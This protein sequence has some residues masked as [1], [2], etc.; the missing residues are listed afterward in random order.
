MT[1]DIPV[2]ETVGMGHLGIEDAVDKIVGETAGMSHLG[3]EEAVDKIVVTADMAGD[4]TV[5]FVL[6]I[7]VG[8]AL[9]KFAGNAVERALVV[10]NPD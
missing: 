7:S 8:E 2:G 1:T 10:E 5:V 9:H 6:G 4:M 3:I